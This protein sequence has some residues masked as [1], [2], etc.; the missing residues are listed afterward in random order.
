M[1]AELE[2]LKL[3]KALNQ[4]TAVIYAVM[5]Y[6]GLTTLQGLS[7]IPLINDPYLPAYYSQLLPLAIL[8]LILSGFA[9]YQLWKFRKLGALLTLASHA[10]GIVVSCLFVPLMLPISSLLTL[11]LLA[12]ALWWAKTE[13]E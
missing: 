1:F 12:Y 3:P 5:I 2:N 9:C 11:G 8:P 4:K 10:V 13:L 6:Q 7:F